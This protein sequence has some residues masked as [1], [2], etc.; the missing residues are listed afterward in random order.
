MEDRFI[1]R[2]FA[3]TYRRLFQRYSAGRIYQPTHSRRPQ[4]RLPWL[5]D[6]Q[7]GHRHLHGRIRRR[8][9]GGAPNT[10]TRNSQTAPGSTPIP[11]PRRQRG[12]SDGF[13]CTRHFRPADPALSTVLHA[14][15]TP[16]FPADPE[17]ALGPVSEQG[18]SSMRAQRRNATL[19]S[20]VTLIHRT[21]DDTLWRLLNLEFCCH[22][23]REGLRGCK[24]RWFSKRS[25]DSSCGHGS[26]ESRQGSR[27]TAPVQPS[28]TTSSGTTAR[29]GAKTTGTPF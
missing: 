14:M 22:L 1:P 15:R 24:Q 8:F 27:Y 13:P 25:P 11:Q 6:N 16:E 7:K 26:C 2:T 18:E 29:E 3:L 10:R 5:L 12:D 21:M 28:Q 20:S 23:H 4:R 17:R 9:T 19:N